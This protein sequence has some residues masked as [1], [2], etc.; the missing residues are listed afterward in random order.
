M[1]TNQSVG[2]GKLFGG[3]WGIFTS[4]YWSLLGFSLLLGGIIWVAQGVSMLIG[5]GLGAGIRQGAQIGLSL[6]YLIGLIVVVPSLAY[7]KYF[8]LRRARWKLAAKGSSP[9]PAKPNM[10]G[11]LVLTGIFQFLFCLPGVIFILSGNP[12]VFTNQVAMQKMITSFLQMEQVDE[13]AQK[14]EAAGEKDKSDRLQKEAKEDT[15][16]LEKDQPATGIM[17]SYVGMLLAGIA[18][19]VVMLFWL[20]WA[21]LGLLDPRTE[22]TSAG[23]AL[24]YGRELTSGNRGAIFLVLIVIV[25]IFIGSFLACCLPAFFFALPLWFAFGPGLYIAMRGENSASAETVTA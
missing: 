16:R 12:E 24:R 19:V 14:A 18:G 7:I 10:Y 15:K 25:L 3:M 11:K 22:V 20:P 5:S 13:E 9:E 2:F 17:L 21:W 1:A 6:N 8:I 23:A 4:C